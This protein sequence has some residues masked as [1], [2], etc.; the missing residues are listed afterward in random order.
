MRFLG[1]VSPLSRGGEVEFRAQKEGIVHTVAG[2]VSFPIEHLAK[3]ILEI[4]CAC[5]ALS[6]PVLP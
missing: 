3:N 4:M 6:S 2:R 1:D 5:A